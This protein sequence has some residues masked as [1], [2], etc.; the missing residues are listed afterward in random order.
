MF[1]CFY[2]AP[3]NE[4]KQVD[5]YHFVHVLVYCV[6]VLFTDFMIL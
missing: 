4:K 6:Y 2:Y 3:E 5:I 1:C